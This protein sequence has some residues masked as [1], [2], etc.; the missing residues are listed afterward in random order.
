MTARRIRRSSKASFAAEEE[1]GEALPDNYPHPTSAAATAVMKG[2]RKRDTRPELALRRALHREGERFRCDFPVSV[3]GRRPIRVDIAFT[4]ARV[5]VFVDGCFW[6]RCPEHTAVPRSNRAYWEP[7]LARNVER[8]RAADRSLLA[9]GWTPVRVWEHESILD[10][11]LRV[12]TAVDERRARRR[13]A[14][15]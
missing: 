13:E 3:G 7:K 5:A 10:A 14:D 6:H 8:D 4:R 15:S 9:S 1:V 12:L 2:N 11:V